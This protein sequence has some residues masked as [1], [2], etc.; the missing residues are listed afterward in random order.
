MNA[1][2]PKVYYNSFADPVVYGM[3]R[4]VVPDS[5]EL[6][7]LDTDDDA[8]R[9]EKIADAEIVIVAATPP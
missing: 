9:M 4:E 1:S 3:I 8:E 2:K 6:V 7:T 5:L